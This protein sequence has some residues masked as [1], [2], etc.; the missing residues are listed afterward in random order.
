MVHR[1]TGSKVVFKSFKVRGCDP[2]T[3]C[4]GRIIAKKTKRKSPASVFAGNSIRVMQ[5]EHV[6][7]D[8][9][10]WLESPAHFRNITTVVLSCS[11][12]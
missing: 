8:C 7:K 12:E 6:E 10:A 11:G 5:R 1:G 4:M 2:R 9:I 3:W